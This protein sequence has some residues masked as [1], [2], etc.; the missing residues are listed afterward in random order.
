M[1]W[2]N[3]RELERAGVEAA[4]GVPAGGQ[5]CG[6]DGDVDGDGP[7]DREVFADVP[8]FS[9]TGLGDASEEWCLCCDRCGRVVRLLNCLTVALP[10][11]KR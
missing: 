11:C 2:K 8:F 5:V 7:L 4:E 10:C 6:E 3:V 1:A 9:W